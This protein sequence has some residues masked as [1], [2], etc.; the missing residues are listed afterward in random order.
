MKVLLRSLPA[1]LVDFFNVEFVCLLMRKLA[2]MH[3]IPV[4]E[5]LPAEFSSEP[6]LARDLLNWM[7]LCIAGVA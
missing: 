5:H 2:Q 6:R 3:T 7:E 4:H 1:E